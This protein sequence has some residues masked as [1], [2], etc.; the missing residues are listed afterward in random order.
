MT[1]ICTQKQNELEEF[2][3]WLMVL[4]KYENEI[5][6]ETA[7]IGHSMGAAFI[8]DYLEQTDKKI[9]AAFLV[10]GHPKP[11]DNEFNYTFQLI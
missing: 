4:N 11:L 1:L 8:L 10:A 7:L 9:K 5:T 3:N 2:E 6:N